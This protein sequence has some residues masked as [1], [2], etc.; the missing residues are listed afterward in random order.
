VG[1]WVGGWVWVVF[2]LYVHFLVSNPSL[3]LSRARACTISLFLSLSLS[4]ALS[5]SPS[6][7]PFPLS[8]PF[9]RPYSIS[10][11]FSPSLSPFP[12]LSLPPL[13]YLSVF[14]PPSL[15]FTPSYCLVNMCARP[16]PPS[17]PSSVSFSVSGLP[18]RP[19]LGGRV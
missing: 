12:P 3:S 7:S 4:L 17:S 18:M 16:P 19:V 5:F 14:L 11:S 10:L 6:L 9:S 8:S 13:L 2:L 1:G 15:L